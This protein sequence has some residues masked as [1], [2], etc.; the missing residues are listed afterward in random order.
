MKYLLKTI[1]ILLAAATTIN[2]AHIKQVNKAP[3]LGQWFDAAKAGNIEQIQALISK[4]DVNAGDKSDNGNTALMHAIK[5]GHELIVKLLLSAPGLNINALNES[6][7][8]ALIQVAKTQYV[9]IAKLL[10]EIPGID[11]NVQDCLGWTSLMFAVQDERGSGTTQLLL[12]VPGLNINARTC[13][14]LTALHHA[15]HSGGVDNVKLLLQA[16]GIDRN[17]QDDSGYNAITWATFDEDYEVMKLLLQYPEIDISQKSQNGETPFKHAVKRAPKI[18][19]LLKNQLTRLAFDAIKKRDLKQLE[20]ITDQ[21][22]IENIV[23]E[24]GDTLVDKAFESNSLE[25]IDFLLKNAQDP[26]TLLARIPFALTNPSSQIFENIMK[27]AYGELST[28]KAAKS[29]DRLCKACAKP[30]IKF[31][32]KC[33]E[34]YYCSADCQKTDWPAHKLTCKKN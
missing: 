15:A 9:A 17:A 5:N 18:T 7:S 21:I 3:E 12:Q 31:C 4:V 33:K 27:L 29:Q 16:P 22:G 28:V 2:S 10:L 1:I 6:H 25:I 13:H 11:V 20:R 30:A 14:R 32:G 24:S 23:N 26:Q 8:T 34:V 19:E